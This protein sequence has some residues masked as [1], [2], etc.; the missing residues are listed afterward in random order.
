MKS[1]NGLDGSYLADETR[2]RRE[3]RGMWGV[4]R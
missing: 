1:A 4:A 2:A 3:G